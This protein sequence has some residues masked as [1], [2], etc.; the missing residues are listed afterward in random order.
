MKF[1]FFNAAIVGM[2]LCISGAANAG[3]I[4]VA[5]N[6]TATQSSTGTWGGIFADANLA[7]DGNTNGNFWN[8]SVAHTLNNY[9]AW[10]MVDLGASYMIEQL[11]IWNRT[12]CCSERIDPY[13]VALLDE[14]FNEVS[15]ELMPS[16][17]ISG[18]VDVGLPT[19]PSTIRYVKIKL[20]EHADYLQLAEVQVFAEVPEPSSL[21]IFALGMIGL[22]SRR[23][24][25]QS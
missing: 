24:K 14:S 3:L 19:H 18:S 2:L 13:Q 17:P 6:G 5:L 7:I 25:K 22:A 20:Y 16:F 10:W 1:K 9:E 23:F 12:D 8:G 21:A 11:V 15:A 4:N